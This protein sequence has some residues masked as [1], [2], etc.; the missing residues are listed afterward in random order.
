MGALVSFEVA[1][2]LR[3]NYNKSPEHL[4]ISGRRAPQVPKRNRPIHQLPDNLFVKELR[5]YNGIPEAVLKHPEIL[6][7]FLPIL[8]ADFAI[9]D[10]YAYTKDAPLTCPISA[11][12]GLSDWA[13]S[14]DDIAAWCHQTS[15][16]FSMRMLRGDHFFIK[17]EYDV[18][19]SAILEACRELLILSATKNNPAIANGSRGEHMKVQGYKAL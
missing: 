13:V 19:L 1:R 14:R 7:L 12:G 16:T 3:Q 8:R 4:F 9:N 15:S 10:A 5:R 18:V 17:N 11:F 6:A 2:L